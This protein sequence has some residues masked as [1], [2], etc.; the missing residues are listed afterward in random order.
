MP[1]DGLTN[2]AAAALLGVTSSAV[3]R[4]AHTFRLVNEKDARGRIVWRADVI[5]KASEIR[6]RTVGESQRSRP[7][8][9]KVIER[10][11]REVE[12]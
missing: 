6:A 3:G 9:E 1:E 4:L 5:R 8:V 12:G 2:S 7:S 11:I 10:A